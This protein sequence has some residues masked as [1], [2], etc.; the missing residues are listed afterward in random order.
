VPRRHV[1][2]VLDQPSQL[3]IIH[4]FVLVFT[5]GF[6]QRAVVTAS[7]DSVQLPLFLANVLAL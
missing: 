3:L 7:I 6:M 4:I 2:V 5:L 1:G